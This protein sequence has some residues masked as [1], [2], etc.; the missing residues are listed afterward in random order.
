MPLKKGYPIGA[1]VKLGRMPNDCWAWNLAGSSDGYG[2]VTFCG[3]QEFAHRWIWLQLFGPIPPGYVIYH[4]CTSKTC[5]N[6]HHLALGLQA[7]ANRHG[8]NTKLLPSDVLCIKREKVGATEHT[9][10]RLASKYAVDVA[11]IYDIWRGTT[12]KKG[13]PNFGPKKKQRSL[14]EQETKR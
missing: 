8:I 11:T 9:A 1:R 7:D 10:R 5:I 13:R 3:E 2:V 6:P 4:T 12:W 14:S